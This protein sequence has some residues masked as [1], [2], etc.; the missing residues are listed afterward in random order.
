MHG[1][2]LPGASLSDLS[3]CVYTLHR[4]PLPQE[5][6]CNVLFYDCT[7]SQEGHSSSSLMKM[8]SRLSDLICSLVH[9]DASSCKYLPLFMG[10]TA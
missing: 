10:S 1:G 3:V 8:G 5:M 2:D 4:L 6:M 7:A 9:S